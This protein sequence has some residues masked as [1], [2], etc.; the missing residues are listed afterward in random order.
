MQRD[1]PVEQAPFMR[2]KDDVE[3]L[4]PENPLIC[5]SYTKYK[6]AH[7]MDERVTDCDTADRVLSDATTLS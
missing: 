4:K 1:C 5:M 6:P 7:R 3:I 2:S